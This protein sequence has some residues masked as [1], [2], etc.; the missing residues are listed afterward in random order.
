VSDESVGVLARLLRNF[1]N[2]E[3]QFGRG[4]RRSLLLSAR[5]FLSLDFI[6]TVHP[7]FDITIGVAVEAA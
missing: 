6:Q 3:A 2:G 1:L 4:K 5:L 7:V